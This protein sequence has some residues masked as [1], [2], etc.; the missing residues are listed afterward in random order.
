MHRAG[1]LHNPDFAHPFLPAA[2]SCWWEQCPQ[3]QGS[4]CGLCCWAQ[5]VVTATGLKLLSL[6]LGCCP[7][8]HDTQFW[9]PLCCPD[10][11]LIKGKGLISAGSCPCEGRA[12]HTQRPPSSVR[13]PTWEGDRPAA[14]AT[15]KPQCFSHSCFKNHFCVYLE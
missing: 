14:G 15:G 1:C 9:S 11:T 8:S 13:K 12:G 10:K 7:S 3:E 6:L 5:A 4:S 2:G